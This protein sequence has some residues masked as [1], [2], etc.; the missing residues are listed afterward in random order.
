[1]NDRVHLLTPPGS[2]GQVFWRELPKKSRNSG[3]VLAKKRR[4]IYCIVYLGYGQAVRDGSGSGIG[5]SVSF[6]VM[7]R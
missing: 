6:V 1:M 7:S 4:V 2:S 5:W 3:G